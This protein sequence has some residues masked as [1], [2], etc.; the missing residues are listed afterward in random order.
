[1]LPLSHDLLTEKIYF[2]VARAY[3]IVCSLLLIAVAIA[4]T[5]L[6]D[7]LAHFLSFDILQLLRWHAQ[8]R[9]QRRLLVARQNVYR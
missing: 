6:E 1:M 8:G 3:I 7:I 5:S 9:L 4:I 2:S